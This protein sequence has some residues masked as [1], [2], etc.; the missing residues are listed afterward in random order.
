MH[1]LFR[2][3]N[4]ARLAGSDMPTLDSLHQ[5]LDANWDREGYATAEQQ[6]RN[7][8]QAHTTLDRFYK[9]AQA[10]AVPVQVEQEFKARLLEED[11]V[12]HGRMDVV[13]DENGIEIRDYKTGHKGYDEKQ[14]KTKASASTQLAVYA[15][16]WQINHD[17]L[18]ARVALHYVDDD[19]VGAVSKQAKSM[20]TLRGKLVQAAEEIRAGRFEPRGQH[21]YCRHPKLDEL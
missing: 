8:V 18:P 15:L 20:D 9:Q 6:K 1:D 5:Q 2:I 17:E 3:I 16:A 7:L 21:K 14:A 11:I 4:E 10:A 13:L 19:L 12:L